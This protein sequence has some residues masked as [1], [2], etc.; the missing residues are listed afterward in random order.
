MKYINGHDLPFHVQEIL[1]NVATGKEEA[2]ITSRLGRCVI[3]S[4]DEYER[5][6]DAVYG[7]S[8]YAWR[9]LSLDRELEGITREER[10]Y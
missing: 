3:I 4:A 2:S 5:L 7:D 10:D 6:Q 9:G 8:S 1:N